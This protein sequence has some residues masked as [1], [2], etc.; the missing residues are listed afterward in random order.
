MAGEPVLSEYVDM[1]IADSDDFPD[2]DCE[3]TVA[4]RTCPAHP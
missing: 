3:G 4:G 2:G 1:S